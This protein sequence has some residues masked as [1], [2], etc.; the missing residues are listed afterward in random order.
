[1]IERMIYFFDMLDFDDLQIYIIMF[2]IF[3]LSI[4]S[5]LLYLDDKRFKDLNDKDK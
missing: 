4:V 5:I 2:A 1:M 3:M